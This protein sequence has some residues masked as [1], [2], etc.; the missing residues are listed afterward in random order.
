MLDGPPGVSE[1]GLERAALSRLPLRSIYDSNEPLAR[2]T[3][4]P[5]H[6]H[7]LRQHGCRGKAV[8][9]S[10]LRSVRSAEAA[11][12]VR[13][14]PHLP[15][16]GVRLLGGV[17]AVNLCMPAAVPLALSLEEAATLDR[18]LRSGDAAYC[19]ASPRNQI[20]SAS[21]QLSPAVGL[22]ACCPSL[23]IVTANVSMTIPSRAAETPQFRLRRRLCNS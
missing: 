8:S 11:A 13:E 23:T 15:I 4:I 7:W 10:P 14:R 9:R 17:G 19:C 22:P 3:R 1:R 5:V 21:P 6:E 2:D 12:L 16:P 20:T 18:E